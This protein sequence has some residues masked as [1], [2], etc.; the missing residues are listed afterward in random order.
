M[1]RK[2]LSGP[3]LGYYYELGGCCHRRDPFNCLWPIKCSSFPYS[4]KYI[5]CFMVFVYWSAALSLLW[6]MELSGAF[7]GNGF[8]RCHACSAHSTLRQ[9]GRKILPIAYLHPASPFQFGRHLD[10]VCV[11][12][13]IGYFWSCA[14][15]RWPRYGCSRPRPRIW[16]SSWPVLRSGYY[17]GR[18]WSYWVWCS[19]PF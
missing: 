5:A 1:N 4:H 3:A 8:L 19:T 12:I 10:A 7:N 6:I 9:N 16:T 14:L 2:S 11:E 18:S 15:P 17:P 13:I